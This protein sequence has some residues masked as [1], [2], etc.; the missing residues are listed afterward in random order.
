MTL[1]PYPFIRAVTLSMAAFWTLRTVLRTIRFLDRW[2]RR[3]APFGIGR[4][5][6]RVQV[7][8]MM[9]RASVLDPLNLALALALLSVWVA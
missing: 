6:L 7:L 4:A 8:R 3:L 9:L 1:E 2:E 5:W